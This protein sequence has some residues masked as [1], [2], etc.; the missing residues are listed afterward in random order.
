MVESPRAN[1]AARKRRMHDEAPVHADPLSNRL[2]L[3]TRC[4]ATNVE[5]LWRP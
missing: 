2:L 1:I 4:W 5:T 3:A